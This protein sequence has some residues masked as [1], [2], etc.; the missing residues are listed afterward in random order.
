MLEPSASNANQRV[1]I[2][3]LT[4]G[5][6]IVQITQQNGPVSIRKSGL[7]TSVDMVQGLAEMGVQEVE[8]DPSQQVEIAPAPDAMPTQSPTQQ[9]LQSGQ[10]QAAEAH[11]R[12]QFNRSLFLPT[13]QALPSFWHYYARQIASLLVVII[14]GGCLGF[15]GA[16]SASW[17]SLF[18]SDPPQLMAEPVT[19]PAPD[20]VA[21]EL[22][23]NRPAATETSQQASIIAS[24]KTEV[25]TTA[26]VEPSSPTEPVTD[27]VA[28]MEQT[29]VL[30]YVPPETTT[31]EQN[32][33]Q[34]GN[35]E[36]QGK[37]SELA[38]VSPDLL[39]K[40]ERALAEV[41]E[42]PVVTPEPQ[43][44]D[45]QR[46]DQLPAR[47][48]TRLPPMEFTAHMYA[49]GAADRWLRVNG[50]EKIEGDWIQDKVRIVRIEPQHVI[51]SFE[52][53]EFSMRALTQW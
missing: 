50:K 23:A 12:D 2:N 48:L 19:Q 11:I 8:V 9:L 44:S 32:S 28:S 46:V 1:P 10:P 20:P 33:A 42:Q 35:E 21:E 40:F 36:Q 6:V 31:A 52:G 49:S 38:G 51:L 37:Q 14:G 43:A 4:P 25:A 3:A 17:L 5:M 13:V 26:A 24:G 30:G 41:N 16:T 34:Q 15:L 45:I 39:R 18:T 29:R 53:E 22:P 7:V 47:L 27:A